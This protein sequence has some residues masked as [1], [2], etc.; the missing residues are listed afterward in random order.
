MRPPLLE[1]ET[2]KCTPIFVETPKPY[3]VTAI[4]KNVCYDSQA[5]YVGRRCDRCCFWRMILQNAGLFTSAGASQVYSS[6]SSHDV[7]SPTMMGDRIVWRSGSIFFVLF[8]GL[9][10][11]ADFVWPSIRIIM[12]MFLVLEWT[13]SYVVSGCGPM[14]LVYHFHLAFRYFVGHFLL[15]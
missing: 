4:D 10:P 11:L 14:V 2:M 3:S 5:L 15:N 1:V 7:L 9:V 12:V 8:V 6:H 13:W